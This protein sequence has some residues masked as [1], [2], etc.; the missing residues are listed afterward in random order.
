MTRK[1][2]E[3]EKRSKHLIKHVNRMTGATDDIDQ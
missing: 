2:P 3:R 1:T